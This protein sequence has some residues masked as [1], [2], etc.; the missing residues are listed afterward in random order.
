MKIEDAMALRLAQ[1]EAQS[2]QALARQKGKAVEEIARLKSEQ[3]ITQM[4]G[5]TAKLVAQ[6]ESEVMALKERAKHQMALEK[7]K[8]EAEAAGAMARVLADNPALLELKKLEIWAE[9]EKERFKTLASFAKNSSAL[10]P[11][12]L[13]RDLLRMRH[14][15]H[16]QEFAPL[17]MPLG[18]ALKVKEEKIDD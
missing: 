7:A 1:V 11:Q 10:L 16:P 3:E 13:Q 18:A 15:A 9:V 6:N 5:E 4:K 12:E 8:S 17:G 2:A 14:G